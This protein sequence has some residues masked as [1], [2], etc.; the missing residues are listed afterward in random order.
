MP[1]KRPT[2]EQLRSIAEDCGGFCKACGAEA[3]V[4]EPDAQ[5]YPCEECGAHKVFGAEELIM[6]G[7]CS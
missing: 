1:A 7:W 2:I 4:V 5:N 3:Y 6:Q